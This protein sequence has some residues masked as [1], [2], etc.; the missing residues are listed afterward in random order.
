MPD[1]DAAHP[2]ITLER[3]H[4]A[5]AAL[6]VARPSVSYQG[7]LNVED[8]DLPPEL[9]RHFLLAG[10][11]GTERQ[12]FIMM[13]ALDAAL[14]MELTRF[15]GS[16]HVNANGPTGRPTNKHYVKL[17]YEPDLRFTLARVFGAPGL[18]EAMRRRD[19]SP[20]FDYSSEA[21]RVVGAGQAERDA[22]G[23]SVSSAVALAE[24]AWS[25]AVE[26]DAEAAIEPQ[27]YL[28]NLNALCRAID[29]ASA[30][31]LAA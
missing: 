9:Q 13:S 28:A 30:E 31:T 26:A 1:R 20:D 8:A 3:L 15:G 10:A 27:A 21:Y 12:A 29:L 4:D 24:E 23:L 16:V 14:L 22:R 6:A 18:H 19:E 2:L 17:H 25:A 7:P 5:A 11:S